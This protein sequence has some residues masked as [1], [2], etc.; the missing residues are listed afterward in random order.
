[1]EEDK[2]FQVFF[3]LLRAGLWNEPVGTTPFLPLSD[4]EWSE[5]FRRSVDQ[6]VDGILYDGIQNLDKK[7]LPPRQI[8]LSW[9]VRIEKIEQRNLWINKALVEQVV[10]F[11]QRDI[12]PWL[13][14]G[15]GIA[16]CYSNPMRRICGDIDWYFTTG[17]MYTAANVYIQEHGFHLVNTA[18]FSACYAWKG[19][20]IDH[21]NHFFDV[22]NPFVISYL[23]R[24]LSNEK[25]HN[26]QLEVSGEQI[27]VPGAN[28]QVL[29]ISTHILKHML[30]FG[31]GFRQLCDLA[32]LYFT[33]NRTIDGALLERC[34]RKLKLWKW[35]NAL[36]KI[37]VTYVGLPE[38]CLPF[39]LHNINSADWMV[40]DVWQ[41]GNF[42]FHDRRYPNSKTRETRRQPSNRLI[43]NLVKYLPLAPM[44]ALCFP[45]VHFY[46]KLIK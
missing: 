1:M 45:L 9:M 2:V 28:L 42:G 33:Y 11:R 8:L 39:A 18:G 26:F 25:I 19:R 38:Q 10:F 34:F 37:L 13:L 22:H 4:V 6:T 30:S 20:E 3:M 41:T 7:F 17:E 21:H 24:L 44:E 35:I 23:K 46:S 36:H 40:I 15:Q 12:E 32:R 5:L 14:K 43:S 27:T 16:A 29:Q 31:I